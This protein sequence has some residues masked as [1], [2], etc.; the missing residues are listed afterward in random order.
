MAEELSV[1]FTEESN[2]LPVVEAASCG[3]DPE[4]HEPAVEPEYLSTG[5]D[6]VVVVDARK[7]PHAIRHKTVFAHL[8]EVAPGKS[9][10]LIAPHDPLPL[11]RQLSNRNPGVFA[12][13][14]EQSGPEDW[15]LRLVRRES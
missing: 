13:E 7:I 6:G 5:A 9:L 4:D 8:D 10:I 14:Y 2:G 11:L 1:V 3:C 12:V 15:R